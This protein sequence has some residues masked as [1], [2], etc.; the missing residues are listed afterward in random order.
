MSPTT[1]F[2]MTLVFLQFIWLALY[3]NYRKKFI[4]LDW[5]QKRL[6]EYSELAKEN[7]QRLEKLILKNAFH[8]RKL[9]HRL[10][11][12]HTTDL[13]FFVKIIK[14]PRS[15]KRCSFCEETLHIGQPR[16]ELKVKIS[17]R[18]PKREYCHTECAQKLNLRGFKNKK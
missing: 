4:G 3:L 15:V 6:F 16:V 10:E 13:F 17:S 9:Y 11:M 14:K 18:Y 8:C 5:L 12:V 1:P 2:I 7:D